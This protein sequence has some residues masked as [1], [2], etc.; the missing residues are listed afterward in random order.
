MMQTLEYLIANGL[1]EQGSEITVHDIGRV[2]S[3]GWGKV[4]VH[5]VGKRVWLKEY[6]I[7]MENSEQRDNRK[8][9]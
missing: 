1:R 8:N 4:F 6:G 9:K 2:I 3:I 5:D 7:V